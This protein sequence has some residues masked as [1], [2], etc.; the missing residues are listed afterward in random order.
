MTLNREYGTI[1]RLAGPILAGQ[2]GSIATGFA[3]NIMV[4]RYSTE[5]LASASFVNNLFNVAILACIGFTMGLTPLVGAL[6]AR[7]EHDRSGA[8]VRSAAIVNT[9]F[10]LLT[11]TVMGVLY[12]CLDNLGQPV[13]LLP[14]IRPYFLLALAGMLPLTLFNVFEQWSF[15]IE[16][17]LAP[18]WIILGGN[19]LNVLGNWLLIYG[20]GGCPEMGLTGAGISTLASR[21]VICVAMIWYFATSRRGRLYRPGFRRA[22]LTFAD[23]RLIV[24]TSLPVSMQMCFETASFG[25]AAIWVGE[26]GT[27]PL[28]AYQIVVITGTLG[29]CIYY[30]AG[31]AISVRVANAAGAGNRAAMRSRAWAGYHIILAIM[32][33]SSLTFIFGGRAIMGAFTDDPKVLALALSLITPLV[34]YQF[35]D[36]TQVT[37][38]NALRGTARVKPMLWISFFSYVVVGLPVTYMFCFTAGWGVYGVVLSFSV[39]LL[40]AAALFLAFFLRATGHKFRPKEPKNKN[41]S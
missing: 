28:A 2:L 26:L 14:L 31:A 19:V 5:A 6:F 11:M 36:A 10:A 12:L 30:S 9:V 35:G 13:E 34:L 17:T 39:S 7:G 3:D 4:G 21:V 27:I 16:S 15:G 22:R 23:V 25:I 32:I 40:T 37:F 1:L 33:L 38:A 18:M 8:L 41:L 24:A 20:V 29:F